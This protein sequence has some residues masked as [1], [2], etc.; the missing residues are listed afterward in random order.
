MSWSTTWADPT[1]T[2]CLKKKKSTESTDG[3]RKQLLNCCF[4]LKK[5]FCFL[6]HDLLNRC[7][8]EQ[9]VSKSLQLLIELIH[10]RI[11]IR[12]FPRFI[13]NPGYLFSAVRGGLLTSLALI[14]NT[15]SMTMLTTIA[16]N[17]PVLSQL[18]CR[19]N[20]LLAPVQKVG[21]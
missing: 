6:P 2:V 1:Q 14:C 19:S 15:M 21:Y 12:Y 9:F 13:K 16:E 5:F 17:C 10:L 11:R 18:W 7:H 4:D 3:L 8:L 20:H